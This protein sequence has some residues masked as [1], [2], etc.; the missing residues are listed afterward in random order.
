V[1]GANPPAPA[2][3]ADLVAAVLVRIEAGERLKEA[4]ADVARQHG[5]VRRDL[6]YAVLDARSPQPPA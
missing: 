1:A 2:D 5:V 4:T 3:T 6:Y